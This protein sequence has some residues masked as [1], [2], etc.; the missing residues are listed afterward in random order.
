[1]ITYG[2]SL[3]FKDLICAYKKSDFI[4]DEEILMYVAMTIFAVSVL[5]LFFYYIEPSISVDDNLDF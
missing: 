2:A 1:L 5:A 4:D 3:I